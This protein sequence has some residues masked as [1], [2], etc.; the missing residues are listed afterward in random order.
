MKSVSFRLLALA[1]TF[2][3]MVTNAQWTPQTSGTTKDLYDSFFTDAQTGWVV[4]SGGTILKTSNG[5]NTWSAISTTITSALNAVFFYNASTGW[6]CGDAGKILKTTDGGASWSPQSLGISVSGFLKDV[7]FVS[8]TTGFIA[9]TYGVY[10]T[11]DGGN[12]WSLS[13]TSNSSQINAVRFANASTGWSAGLNGKIRMTTDGGAT[14]TQ[15]NQ[16]SGDDYYDLATTSTGKT[17]FVG[18]KNEVLSTSN[19]GQNFVSTTA[20]SDIHGLC[21][22]DATNGWFC[23][24]SGKIYSTNDAGNS[25]TQVTSGSTKTLKDIEFLD[26]S[27]GWCV[28]YGG[29][30][31]RYTGSAPV[32]LTENVSAKDL[33]QIIQESRQVRAGNPDPG[34]EARLSVYSVDGRL[35]NSQ[36]FLG[37][38]CTLPYH[39]F[40]TGLYVLQLETGHTV[41]RKLLVVD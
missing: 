19:G 22:R 28:G 7:F 13:H 39:G 29:T 36:L 34:A 2:N 27:T 35:L 6:I 9:G 30:I 11:T 17:F 40:T 10:K 24:T 3:S 41:A 26:S 15:V 23:G 32:G 14:W 5:G 25:W 37:P 38:D 33:L 21:F 18:F 1:L 12:T 4:G 31:L 20:P 8:P 16:S